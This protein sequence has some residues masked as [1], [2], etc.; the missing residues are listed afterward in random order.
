MDS[1][2][3]FQ[4]KDPQCRLKKLF[5]S[6]KKLT[7]M[8]YSKFIYYIWDI[9]KEEFYKRWDSGEFKKEMER[10]N[11]YRK[12]IESDKR[13]NRNS[14]AV[15]TEHNIQKR[16]MRMLYSNMDIK[17]IK[18]LLKNEYE[19]ETEPTL[20]KLFK[21]MS[22]ISEKRLLQ[23]RNEMKTLKIEDRHD[24]IISMDIDDI[25]KE[26]MK[27]KDSMIKNGKYIEYKNTNKKNKDD[28]NEQPTAE[29]YK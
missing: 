17:K 6:Q 12:L 14:R 9:A 13:N 18:I 25:H 23:T 26:H 1:N 3:K 21:K 28:N 4:I 15:W 7:G 24:H 29:T 27:L 22:R 8:S 11:H 10:E 19:T 16:L 20:K 5:R 2:S